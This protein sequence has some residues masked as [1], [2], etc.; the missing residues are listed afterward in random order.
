MSKFVKKLVVSVSLVIAIFIF[1]NFA[2]VNATDLT[3]NNPGIKVVKDYY[4][5]DE[6]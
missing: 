3:G 4:N 5:E 6:N 1:G 2:K